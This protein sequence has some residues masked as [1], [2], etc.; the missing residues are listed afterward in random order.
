MSLVKS[1]INTMKNSGKN[2]AYLCK[3]LG[4]NIEGPGAEVYKIAKN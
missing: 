1:A 4:L 2:F 3:G